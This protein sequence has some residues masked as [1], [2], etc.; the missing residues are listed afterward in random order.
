MASTYSPTL[1]IELIGTGDQSGLWGDT[2]NTNLG[3]LIEQAITGVES[4]PMLDADYTLSALNGSVDEARN[5][6]LIFTSVGTLT[7]SRNIIIPAVEKLYIV[8]NSTTGGQN[9]VIKT[10][11]GSG[12]TI[13]NGQSGLL[14]C[15]GTN[16]YQAITYLNSP[17][18]ATPTITG[19]ASV[20]G[21]LNV[22]GVL[23]AGVGS[24]T[25]LN[26]NNY[27]TYTPTLSGTGAT[28]TWNIGVLGNAA[29]ATNSTNAANLV[30]SNWT[31][32]ESGGKLY[33]KYGGV[34]KMSLD[35][36]GNII[37]TGNV[38]AYGTP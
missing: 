31:V 10:S 28:G 25:V 9:L 35:S 26:S 32:N 6:V 21:N 17:T 18:L 8:K 5:A 36:S 1:R 27:N 11:G 3:S 15:D 16:C 38:T 12:Y 19:N 2:T 34:N 24:Y 22:A 7:G 30:T 14:Y 13:P 29:T 37:V 20:S 33:F 4:I 23:T